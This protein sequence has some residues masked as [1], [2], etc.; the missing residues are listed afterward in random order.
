[1][2]EQTGSSQIGNPMA[3]QMDSPQMAMPVFAG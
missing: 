3:E 2:T 1:M